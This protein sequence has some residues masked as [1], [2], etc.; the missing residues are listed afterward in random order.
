MVKQTTHGLLNSVRL[1][2]SNWTIW[3]CPKIGFF[4]RNFNQMIIIWRLSDNISANYL[5]LTNFVWFLSHFRDF[6]F[7]KNWLEMTIGLGALTHA[8]LSRPVSQK[9]CLDLLLFFYLLDSQDH[10][11]LRWC[12]IGITSRFIYEKMAIY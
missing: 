11:L 7:S 12:K 9:F 1:P 5:L 4:G 2:F 8:C 6:N 10:Y 3:K